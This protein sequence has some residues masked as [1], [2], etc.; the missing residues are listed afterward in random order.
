MSTRYNNGSHYENHQRAAE[1]HDRAAHAHRAAAEEHGKK[2]HQT[3]PG[4]VKAYAGALSASLPAYST[5]TSESNKRA[6]HR[7]IRASGHCNARVRTLACERLSRG[8][9]GGR[10][11]PC[12]RT[13]AV[14][15]VTS[16]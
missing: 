10:L 5:G 16:H 7:R 3:G 6:W 1:L 4:A 15:Q 11:V 9:T 12:R 8:I 2:D 14:S 13:I